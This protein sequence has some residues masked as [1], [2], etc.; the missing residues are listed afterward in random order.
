MKLMR[1]LFILVFLAAAVQVSAAPAIEV[2]GYVDARMAFDLDESALTPG[3]DSMELWFSAQVNDWLSASIA[4]GNYFYDDLEEF[5]PRFF[6]PALSEA[7]LV[8][9]WEN[10]GTK[11]SLG[12]GLFTVP[13]GIASE[14]AS[15]P[16]NAFA[17]NPGV[18]DAFFGGWWGDYGVFG[19]AETDQF[20]FTA[21]LV[22]GDMVDSS[23]YSALGDK[24][25]AA[26]FRATF[27]PSEG[28]TVG[29]SCAMNAHYPGDKLSLVAGDIE[30]ALGPLTLIGQYSAMM[31]KFEFGDRADTWFAQAVFSLEDMIDM[32]LFLGVRFD[33]FSETLMEGESANAITLQLAYQ[34]ED[35]FRL[36]LSFRSSQ[37]DDESDKV[38]M[39][40]A[41][42][43][44]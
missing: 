32:P 18:T 8:G 35:S 23:A 36:G 3:V 2:G 17:Y 5:N 43:M 44:F 13:F 12:M 27:S 38:I 19:S 29:L 15:A 14:W 42:T 25:L 22:Q 41:M 11:L 24:G 20:G 37:L 6:N 31:S 9:S 10:D 21:Y 4:L 40:Q 39:L 30:L 1:L 33:Y 7:V 16:F 26:G 34:L 28:V